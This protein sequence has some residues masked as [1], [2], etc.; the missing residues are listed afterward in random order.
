M[1]QTIITAIN[2]RNVLKFEYKGRLRILNP[3]ALYREDQHGA[4]VLHAWQTGGQSSTRVPPCW[5]NF[6]LDEII[7]LTVLS[8]NFSAPQVDFN[9]ER[10]L[11]LI[12]SIQTF[13]DDNPEISVAE[14]EQPNSL[15]Y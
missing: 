7:G 1:K 4:E 8:E 13:C 12:H 3:H 14:S 15:D 2:N 6:H 9:P 10:F 11:H 5:G